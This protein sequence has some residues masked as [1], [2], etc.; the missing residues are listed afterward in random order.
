M[1]AG[2]GTGCRTSA[3]DHLPKKAKPDRCG[4]VR[5]GTQYC[6]CNDQLCYSFLFS[7]FHSLSFC[8]FFFFFHS[9]TQHF[10][11]SFD[12]QTCTPT[13][14]GLHYIQWIH[15]CTLSVHCGCV[16]IFNWSFVHCR[17]F[18]ASASMDG[19]SVYLCCLDTFQSSAGWMHKCRKSC[20]VTVR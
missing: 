1:P 3:R 2:K 5:D 4:V 20:V 13:V 18:S 7:F 15:V 6:V 9:Y 17:V 12:Q 10:F 11:M 14:D 16:V 8:S 19:R